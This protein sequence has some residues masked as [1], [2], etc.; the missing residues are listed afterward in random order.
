[1][2]HWLEALPAL[3]EDPSSASPSEWQLPTVSNFISR[4]SGTTFWSLQVLDM[5]MMNMHTVSQTLT[6]IK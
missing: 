5:Q 3:A 4:G 2:A 6:T 1:M